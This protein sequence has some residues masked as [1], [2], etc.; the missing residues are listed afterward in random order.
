MEGLVNKNMTV[1]VDWGR[2]TRDCVSRIRNLSDE[3]EDVDVD[4]G[5]W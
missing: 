5:G 2:N 1:D 3:G 4:G